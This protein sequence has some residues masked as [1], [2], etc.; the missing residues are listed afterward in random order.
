MSNTD[1][2][3]RLL[4][5]NNPVPSW[6]YDRETLR[7][8]MVNDAAI[9]HYGYSRE[10][11][12]A[13]S[14]K[15]IRPAEEV[16]ALIE[17]VR[18]GSVESAVKQ[19]HHRK[20]DGTVITVEIRAQDF[21]FEGRHARLV[22]ATDVTARE[23]L[24]HQLRQSQKMEVVGQ[25]AGGVAHDFNNL[26]TVILSYGRFVQ[27]QLGATHSS[28]ED[29]EEIVQSAERAA[30]LTRQL[31]AFSRR[32]VLSPQVLDL[33]TVV[34]NAK[35]FLE[36]LIGSNIELVNVLGATV[37]TTSADPGLLD[38]VIMNLAVNARDA[39]PMGGKLTLETA[40]VEL[41]DQ[42]ARGHLG[43][44]PGPYVMLAVTDTGTGMDSAT[45]ARI[46]EPFF[47]TKQPGKGTG[48]GLSTV[49]GIVK[50]SGGDLSVYSVPGR[51]TSFK[52]YLPR[53]DEQ[54]SAAPAPP[55]PGPHV[56]HHETVLLVEDD[57]AVRE[58]ARRTL[59]G[60]GYQVLEAADAERAIAIESEHHGK[61]QL[62]LTDIVMPNLNGRL[63]AQRLKAASPT[64]K[65]LLMSGYPGGAL[66]HQGVL[67]PGELHLQKP[68]TP[69]RL[70]EK[71]RLA[72]A[73]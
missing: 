41:D 38:Q 5:A 20:K 3:Y 66:G 49:F 50:Q 62:L 8:L 24:E 6:V 59:A 63:L 18:R 39:M 67:E 42:F 32:Q 26:L 47:T 4:F 21:D 25:L 55:K 64:L 61:I 46:F 51:G 27:D 22:L 10:E 60:A 45:Q 17:D 2:R 30:A 34:T 43:A 40:D 1:D 11:F 9:R 36:R 65:T 29:L 57:P 16:Q 44:R 14:L 12:A 53:A 73:R 56:T 72:L 15:D 71:V 28:Y 13:M 70:L 23:Q 52:V 19:W 31:L 69:E 7:F 58:A 33:N 68:F 48:L 54:P 37:G 35:K